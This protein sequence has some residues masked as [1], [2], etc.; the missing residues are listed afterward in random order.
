MN[1]Q[2]AGNAAGCNLS[3]GFTISLAGTKQ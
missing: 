2:G 1:A 3:K